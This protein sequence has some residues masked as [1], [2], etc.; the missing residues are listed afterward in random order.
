M[1]RIQLMYEAAIRRRVYWRKVGDRALLF[2]ICV[3]IPYAA[4]CA[5]LAIWGRNLL[6]G[7]LTPVHAIANFFTQ[8]PLS[9]R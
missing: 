1:E 4:G 6:P 7:Y 2:V 8:I 5:I 3:V 9:W